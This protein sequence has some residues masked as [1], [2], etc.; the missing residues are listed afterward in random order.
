MTSTDFYKIVAF[1]FHREEIDKG[2]APDGCKGGNLRFLLTVSPGKR[3][4]DKKP[5]G[6]CSDRE[7]RTLADISGLIGDWNSKQRQHRRS[8]YR[9]GDH[10]DK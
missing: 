10:T 4:L 1:L 2:M 9:K 8:L 5:F 3:G 6:D 7:F